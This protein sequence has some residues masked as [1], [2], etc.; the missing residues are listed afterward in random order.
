MNIAVIFA[1]G[2]GRRMKTNNRTPKQFLDV[3]GK[4][5]LIH[6]LEKFE[7]NENIDAIVIA[8]VGE[9][10]DYCKKIIEQFKITKV[11]KIVVG[12][13]TGQES[14]YNGLV[15]AKEIAS[16]HE[17]VVLIHDGVRPLIDDELI[18]NNVNCVRENGSAITCTECKET[19]III[20]ES[21][22][23]KTTTNRNNTRIAK[24]PQSFYLND[25]LEVHKQALRDGN[26][27]VID[28]CTLMSL[29]NKKLHMIM[30][31]S[32]NIKI[33]TPDDYYI[34]KAILE[35]KENSKNFDI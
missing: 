13:S 11:K 10:I 7:N 1:G 5:I 3:N 15:A 32:E 35:S 33:T 24:A 23:I 25:I 22:E 2:V 9:W 20:D 26:N 31:K 30:G 29:Y 28:S 17:D 21:G 34:F 18:N 14:I 27:N 4:P 6:T 16:G 12:G 8:C 19:A